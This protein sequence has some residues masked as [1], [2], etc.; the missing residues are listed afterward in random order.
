MGEDEVKVAV[1]LK[2]GA[3]LKPEEVL[4]FCKGRMAYYAIPRYVEFVKEIP[5]TETHRVQYGVLR[6]RGITP[7]DWDREKA[8]YQVER[9]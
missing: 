7:N 5:K 2:P 4:D 9:S 8:G 1:V 6:S 3:S